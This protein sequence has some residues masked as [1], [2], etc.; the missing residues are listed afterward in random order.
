M[1]KNNRTGKLVLPAPLISGRYEVTHKETL[2]RAL[3]TA[4]ADTWGAGILLRIFIGTARR[5]L[6]VL[7]Y[8][9]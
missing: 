7:L 2:H 8:M 4:K 1:R 6:T 3:K 9:G 5:L